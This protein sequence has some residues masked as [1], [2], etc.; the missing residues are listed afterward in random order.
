MCINTGL[1]TCIRGIVIY[2]KSSLLVSERI[3][4]HLNLMMYLFMLDLGQPCKP[5]MGWGGVGECVYLTTLQQC[6]EAGPAQSDI[7]CHGD[8]VVM[9]T[10]SANCNYA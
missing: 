10:E 1:E 8:H 5:G 6:T 7:C 4:F 2:L 9:V 3:T